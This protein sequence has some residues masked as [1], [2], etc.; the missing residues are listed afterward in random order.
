MSWSPACRARQPGWVTCQGCK[1]SKCQCKGG[2]ARQ[3]PSLGQARAGSG[4]GGLHPAGRSSGQLVYRQ[5]GQPRQQATAAS[6]APDDAQLARTSDLAL[7]RGG[8]WSSPAQ[9]ARSRQVRLVTCELERYAGS[10]AGAYRHSTGHLDSC[11]PADW[12]RA[13]PR[14][15]VL[16]WASPQHRSKRLQACSDTFKA[17][18]ETL[19]HSPPE[20]AAARALTGRE[21]MA[22]Y[23]R[24]LTS[25]PRSAG[26]QGCCRLPMGT[27]DSTSAPKLA[28][29]EFGRGFR[30][31]LV[32]P[33]VT[34][35]PEVVVELATSIE[36]AT[37]VSDHVALACKMYTGAAVKLAQV[38]PHN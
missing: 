29:T 36:A 1:A 35:N 19:V 15:L 10:S 33:E 13:S 6:S 4:L 12:P 16:V 5:P 23:R 24:L 8:D 31:S 20:I 21:L 32:K 22:S 9:T 3:A 7:D 11:R 30:L 18:A 28:G 14:G 38:S 27:E 37:K 2:V 17:P 34:A 26:P 25:A